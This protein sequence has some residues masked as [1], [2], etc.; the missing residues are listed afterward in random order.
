MTYRRNQRYPAGRGRILAIEDNIDQAQT[1]AALL[2]LWG[3]EVTTANEIT[4]GI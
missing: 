4:A 1:L 2:S 3:H